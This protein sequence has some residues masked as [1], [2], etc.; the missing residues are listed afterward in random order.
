MQIPDRQ[1]VTQTLAGDHAAYDTL[2]KRY[3]RIARAAAMSTV[4]DHHAAQD[5]AQ[6]AFVAAY[7]KLATLRRPELFGPW[8]MKITKRQALRWAKQ[9][10]QQVSLNLAHTQAA[11]GANGQLD[12]DKQRLLT[13]VQKLPKH[14]R[15]VIMLRYFEA[16][17]INDVAQI[18]ARPVGTVTKQIS[19]ALER[20]QTTLNQGS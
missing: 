4:N 14:E 11:P 13:A 8:L 1:L 16:H 3:Q 12:H 2:V 18:T 15:I 5:V 19:R 6:D 20:L 7:Q 17:S 10:P 9:H